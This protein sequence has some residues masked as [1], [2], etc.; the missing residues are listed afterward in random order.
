MRSNQ[1]KSLRRSSIHF[2]FLPFAFVP[3]N[4]TL[5]KYFQIFSNIFKYFQ[6]FSN[7]F[8]Y[9]QIFATLFKSL[10]LFSLQFLILKSRQNVFS[11]FF[12]SQFT[13]FKSLS[14]GNE[15]LVSCLS[16]HFTSLVVECRWISLN[17][18]EYRLASFQILSLHQNKFQCFVN[19]SKISTSQCHKFWIRCM[20][21][22][23]YFISNKIF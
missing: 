11:I 14:T 5:C 16:P 10:W 12:I 7:T 3:F 9:L 8:K 19:S 15:Y 18:V 21:L 22:I 4:Y 6:I 13:S 20:R 17:I 1:I 23:R 2:C